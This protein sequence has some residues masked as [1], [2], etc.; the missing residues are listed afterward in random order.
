MKKVESCIWNIRLQHCSQ[1]R[2][3]W[4]QKPNVWEIVKLFTKFSF[5]AFRGPAI[6]IAMME[7]KMVT[8]IK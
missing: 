2:R 8:K 4:S 1:T 6:L 3:M 7:D 5:I